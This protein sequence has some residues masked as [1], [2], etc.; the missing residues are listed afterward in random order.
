MSKERPSEG[1]AT[2]CRSL[3]LGLAMLCVQAPALAAS[4]RIVFAS[5]LQAVSGGCFRDD[6][7]GCDLFS[8]LYDSGTK[9]VSAITRLTSDA[10][11]AEIFPALSPDGNWLAYDHGTNASPA[12]HEL[13]LIHLP[14]GSKTTLVSDARFPEWIDGT[15]LLYS[16]V[17]PGNK[18]VALLEL[19]LGGSTPRTKSTQAICNTSRCPGTAA[20]EDPFPFPGGT[21]IAFQ[22]TKSDRYI[23]GLS[24]INLDGSSFTLANGWDGSGHAIVST[25]GDEVLYALASSGALQVLN[26]TSGAKFALPLASTGS[27]LTAFD[28]RYASASSLSWAY[29]AWLDGRRA[30]LLSGAGVD[31][32]GAQ[33]MS[34]LFLGEFD[35]AWSSVTITDLATAIERA[36]GKNGKD[37]CTAAARLVTSGSAS[38]SP[39]SPLLGIQGAEQGDLAIIRSLGANTAQIPLPKTNAEFSSM[40]AQASSADMKVLLRADPADIQSTALKFDTAKLSS[41]VTGVKTGLADARIAGLLIAE[42][43]CQENPATH[44]RQW[45]INAAELAS[46]VS[47]IKAIVP[48]LAVAVAFNKASCLDSFVAAATEGANIGDIALLN[49]FYYKWNT[50]A[51][52]IDSYQYSAMNFK[53]F[54]PAAGVLPR[55]GVIERLGEEASPFPS[56]DWIVARS[57]EFFAF[58]GAFD[59]VMYYDYRQQEALQVKNIVN[60]IGEA[61]Y[62]AAFQSVFAAAQSVYGVNPAQQSFVE[63]YEPELDHY[64]ITADSNEQAFIYTGGAGNW[65]RTGYAFKEGGSAPVC[66]FYGNTAIN[67]ATGQMF[68]PNSHF[69]TVNAAECAGLKA[70]YNPKA[71]SWQFESDSDQSTAALSG[72]CASGLVPVYR[73]Y[74]N[75]YARGVDSNHRLSSD[76]AAYLATVAAG[77]LAEG[78]VMCA[79]Q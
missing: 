25:A 77:W 66:R 22:S 32:H 65:Q 74:N 41:L 14:T 55:I 27:T 38:T 21:R 44:T 69:Y 71:P 31:S 20:T 43:L 45:N 68:G 10:T 48:S 15:H 39:A 57:K 64:F 29:A 51:K 28:P 18:H 26:L 36:A 73:A 49:L 79:P 60:V 72:T 63:Y 24:F 78:V 13:R 42:D 54:A 19:D 37:F 2:W 56:A 47:T 12:R 67:P 3:A 52:L 8:A 53:R 33:F 76:Y 40:L 4:Y 9:T 6:T 30:L 46:A 7:S 5:N 34:R 62:V 58:G 17:A 50:T 23:A 70:A 11:A 35:A 59:G 61:S 16:S 75:G 1:N